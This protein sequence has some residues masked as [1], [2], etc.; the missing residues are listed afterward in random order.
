MLDLKV[1]V[2]VV[3][4]LSQVAQGT[5]Y[6]LPLGVIVCPKVGTLKQNCM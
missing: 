4:F 1:D 6:G 2:T 5:I 3:L